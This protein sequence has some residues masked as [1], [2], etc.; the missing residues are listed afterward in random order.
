MEAG[1]GEGR[2]KDWWGRNFQRCIVRD[3][4]SARPPHALQGEE[5]VNLSVPKA[6]LGGKMNGVYLDH[7]LF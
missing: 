7:T 1:V 6:V 2:K 3:R 4:P 5:D